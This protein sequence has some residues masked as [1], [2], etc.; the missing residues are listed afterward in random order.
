MYIIEELPIL[1]P[2]NKNKYP[3]WHTYF[4]RIYKQ[5]VKTSVNLN[6]FTWFYYS[7]PFDDIDKI[8]NN[9]RQ[10]EFGSTYDF[11]NT[12]K[13]MLGYTAI[14]MN[15]YKQPYLKKY[16]VKNNEGFIYSI[17]PFERIYLKL[18]NIINLYGFFVTRKTF[19]KKSIISSDRCEILRVYD[20]YNITSWQWIVKGSGIFLNLNNISIERHIYSSRQKLNIYNHTTDITNMYKKN[21]IELPKFLEKNNIKI[22]IFMKAHGIPELVVRFNKLK[23][24]KLCSF[25][26]KYY[27][28]GYDKQTNIKCQEDLAVINNGHKSLYSSKE[29]KLIT[30]INNPDIKS[31][32]IIKCNNK[33]INKFIPIHF[34]NVVFKF[35]NCN[36]TIFAL[37]I[38][39]SKYDIILELEKLGGSLLCDVP[40]YMLSKKDKLLYKKYDIALWLMLIYKNTYI[41]NK[42]T[43]K[44]MIKWLYTHLNIETKNRLHECFIITKYNYYTNE[45]NIM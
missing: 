5:E 8:R 42:T 35:V 24:N 33:D 20:N 36:M 13:K 40:K 26:N 34:N 21:T 29:Y 6:E 7:A 9:M 12:N 4:K 37:S 17:R 16:S 25:P 3:E 32:G 19:N 11:N 10:C 43:N 22:F 44:K 45:W 41:F 1:T 38:L 2:S 28:T 30:L 15:K 27:S 23:K 39:Q 18:E 14:K 31:F